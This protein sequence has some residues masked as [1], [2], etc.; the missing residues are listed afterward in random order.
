MP[1]LRRREE[2]TGA[3]V[4]EDVVAADVRARV[5]RVRVTVSVRVRVSRA[6]AKGG[7]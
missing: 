2:H 3:A 4:V 6:R 7:G 5:A 1:R